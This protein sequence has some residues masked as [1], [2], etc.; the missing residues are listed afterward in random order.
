MGVY[1]N[2]QSK[3]L[4][5]TKMAKSPIHYSLITFLFNLTVFCDFIPQNYAQPIPKYQDLKNSDSIDGPFLHILEY[6]SITKDCNRGLHPSKTEAKDLE[7]C[8]F[9]NTKVQTNNKRY[10]SSISDLLQKCFH[11]ISNKNRKHWCNEDKRI[12][13]RNILS[14]V[15]RRM[16]RKVKT[17]EIR[18]PFKYHNKQKIQNRS[19]LKSELKS[20]SDSEECETKLTQ[21]FECYR[22]E[23]SSLA[24]SLE[25]HKINALTPES[26]MKH[27]NEAGCELIHNILNKCDQLLCSPSS[28]SSSNVETYNEYVRTVLPGFDV[29]KCSRF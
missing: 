12:L 17:G 29:N 25:E 28:H 6:K 8:V 16:Q 4:H 14:V 2:H 13:R 26:Q 5:T 23:L 10:R 19:K 7:L 1:L 21:S 20:E 18:E 9:R 15:I 3:E 11:K 24:T 27:Q 22:S